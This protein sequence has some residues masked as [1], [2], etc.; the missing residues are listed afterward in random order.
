MHLM[1]LRKNIA[2]S[3]NG[4]IF[5]PSTGDSY[6]AN[7]VAAAILEQLK[8]GMTFSDIKTALLDT[9]EVDP[10]RLER[11]WDDFINQLREASLLED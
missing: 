8:Q 1:Y 10:L 7:P 9:Y 2:T 5:N 11:D 3:E 4:F 6:S